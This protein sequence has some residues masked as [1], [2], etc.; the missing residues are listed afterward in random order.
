MTCT[1]DLS[2][3]RQFGIHLAQ[4]KSISEIKEKLGSTIEGLNTV[5]SAHTLSRKFDLETPLI[6]FVYCCIS[7]ELSVKDAFYKFIM[8]P[9]TQEGVFK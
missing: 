5:K 9:Q 8:R 3:N 7:E 1:G 6:D 2:R 4:D